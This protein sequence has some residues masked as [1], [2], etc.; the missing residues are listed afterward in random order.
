VV[1][2]II[3]SYVSQYCL[4]GKK[5][6]PLLVDP[7]IYSTSSETYHKLGEVVGQAFKV[8]KEL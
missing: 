5:I 8:G 4:Q 6:D 1:G 3:Q 7:L 2:E